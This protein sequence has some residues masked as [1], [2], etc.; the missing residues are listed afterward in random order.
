MMWSVLTELC[1]FRTDQ[2]LTT[3][4]GI[5]ALI[6]LPG[7]SHIVNSK[8]GKT[9]FWLGSIS[10]VLA[11]GLT[12]GL[13]KW[14]IAHGLSGSYYANPKWS[15]TPYVELDRYFETNGRRI[16]RFIDFN[17]NDFNDRYP[18]SGKPFSVKWQGYVYIPAGGYQLGVKSNF[19]TWL[20]VG[21]DLIDGHHQ[22]DFGAPEARSY[23]REGWSV[24]EQWGEPSPFSFIWSSGERSEFYLGVDQVAAYQLL[25]RCMP[26]V[27]EGSPQQEVTVYIAGTPV[28]TITLK[29]GWHTYRVA[30]PQAILQNI[31]PGF[32]R[33]KFAY[34]QRAR[35][36]EVIEHA[37]DEREL[38]VA[39]DFAMLQKFSPQ[40][41]AQVLP[42]TL[43]QSSFVSQRLY[44]I[45][46]KALH[47]TG[48]D[49]F[50]RLVWKRGQSNATEVLPED[51]LFPATPE[52]DRISSVLL[53]E[54]IF[55]GLS[56]GL[57]CIALTLLTGS[58][59]FY[60][61]GPHFRKILT[62]DAAFAS[63]I[64]ILAF[65]LL[66]FFL[67]ERV[68]NDPTF[69]HLPAG[70]DQLGFLFF[71]RGFLRGYW[72][73]Y[74]HD[75]IAYNP[76]V[77]FFLIMTHLVFG[78]NLLI[79]R[80]LVSTMSA[81]SVACVYT[82][83]KKQFNQPVA[84]LAS[85]LCALNGVSICYGSSL[86]IA[87]QATFLNVL[88]LWF[89][90]RTY[91]NLS[92]RNAVILGMLFGVL[93]FA[94]PTFLLFLPF[95]FLKMFFVQEQSLVRKLRYYSISCLFL[96]LVISP[97]TIYNYYSNPSHQ[98]VLLTNSGGFNFWMGNNPKAT[99]NFGYHV[100][101]YRETR[102]R[103][104]AADTTYFN[105]VM[106]FVKEHPLAYLTLQWKKFLMFWRGFEQGN[107]M[108][109]Y[110]YREHFSTLL[111]WP[112]INF[113]LIG[114]LGIIGI[115]LTCKAYRKVYLLH[116]FVL[117]QLAANVLFTT[118]ARFRLPAVP[119]ISIFA[120]YTLYFLSQ[121]VRQQRFRTTLLILLLFIGI[122]ASL[123]YPYAAELYERLYHV[124]MP[125]IRTLRYWDIF[126]FEF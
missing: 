7:Y 100:P 99:G 12:I 104:K 8:R 16:D 98:F 5:V 81:V 84:V 17:P 11:F 37:Q 27:Y 33:V 107:L 32:F 31:A 106:L 9:L 91:K 53:R 70:T 14:R 22:I 75:P 108:S 119:I 18:F 102:A 60:I 87:P 39:F 57:T 115:L 30:I 78:E 69:Y 65:G 74:A 89:V 121:A 21:D 95:L 77:T 123:N 109:Y 10:V 112:F 52:T 59:V 72:P 113:V 19:G 126:H 48:K 42:Q 63:G 117:T 58:I 47:N 20:Y 90:H 114:P 44:R 67:F 41:T 94:R 26:F 51:Y 6:F 13:Y 49:P 28:E 3:L 103:I 83:T 79:S 76:L 122:Y 38:A 116:T 101:L 34:A 68:K 55:L 92:G 56:I 25:F 88:M 46:L 125:L 97:V 118:S 35:P 29:E 73:W 93:A 62:K 86:L 36:S 24:D 45:T 40:S 61:V 124:K 120:A 15:D 1:H 54:R 111:K 80:V 66:L 82:I 85:L 71:A 43:P 4:L 2:F 23:L 96:F 64:G 105:E 50:V 110:Y